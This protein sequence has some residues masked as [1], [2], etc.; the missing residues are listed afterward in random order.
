MRRRLISA[1]RGC[2]Q[3]PG[4]VGAGGGGCDRVG[5]EVKVREVIVICFEI[6]C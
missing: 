6:C 5:V 4:G 2:C 3:V 1:N